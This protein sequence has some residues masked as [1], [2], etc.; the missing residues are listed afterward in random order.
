MKRN[1]FGVIGSILGFV[2]LVLPWW[3]MDYSSSGTSAALSLYLY[4]S[5]YTAG[6]LTASLAVVD[7]FSWTALGLLLAAS[8]LVLLASLFWENGRIALL[9]GGVLALLSLIVFAAGLQIYLS[10]GALGVF[11]G[12]GLFSSGSINASGYLMKFSTYLTFGFWLSAVAMLFMLLAWARYSAEEH[13]EE[14]PE[15]PEPPRKPTPPPYVK[16]PVGKGYPYGRS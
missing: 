7:W 3:S 15:E 4:Q 6:N 14:K 5:S 12:I 9:G 2:S 16:R 10:G 1:I 11:R 13:K 8:V